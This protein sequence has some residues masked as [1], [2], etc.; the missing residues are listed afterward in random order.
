MSDH[1]DTRNF[2]LPH[3]A[4]LLKY[5][6]TS[7]GLV[8]ESAV[9]YLAQRGWKFPVFPGDVEYIGH[10]RWIVKQS[11]IILN[12]LALSFYLP[13]NRKREEQQKR[14]QQINSLLERLENLP[15]LPRAPPTLVGDSVF[16]WHYWGG[17]PFINEPFRNDFFLSMVAPEITDH[18]GK[19]VEKLQAK[20]QSERD[21]V[22]YIKT[23]MYLLRDIG[24]VL[25]IYVKFVN[26]IW[27][28][29]RIDSP[30]S[31]YD[32]EQEQRY[33]AEVQ[34]DLELTKLYR[35]FVYPRNFQ[36]NN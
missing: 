4:C 19:L 3:S 1:V 26:E 33:Q 23:V 13:T 17:P 6:K 27:D 20:D 28:Y 21:I 14:I 9:I 18:L 5:K 36:L 25:F 8:H 31:F 2:A 32:R 7:E 35:Y 29:I 22:T 11:P 16:R 34:G 10:L 12:R 24:W 15:N 30:L